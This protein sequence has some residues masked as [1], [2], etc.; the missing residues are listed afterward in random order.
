MT[1][2]YRDAVEKNRLA[3]AEQKEKE[4]AI[5]GLKM[6]IENLKKT[7]DGEIAA[8]KKKHQKLSEL[9]KSLQTE[10]NAAVSD[11][12]QLRLKIDGLTSNFFCFLGVEKRRG[13]WVGLEG[14][15][16]NEYLF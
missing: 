1:K 5:G 9:C 12:V 6:D 11:N 14:F 10:R 3:E 13:V 8:I 15:L 7:H 2:K 4:K 16:P